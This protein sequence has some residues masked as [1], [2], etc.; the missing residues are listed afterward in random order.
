VSVYFSTRH[1]TTYISFHIM[2]NYLIYVWT[3]LAVRQIAA[4]R[5]M[6]C[7]WWKPRL[8]VSGD[9]R[10]QCTECACARRWGAGVREDWHGSVRAADGGLRGPRMCLNGNTAD[11]SIRGS[12]WCDWTSVVKS[13]VVFCSMNSNDFRFHF[14]TVCSCIWV[15][16]DKK[17]WAE[18]KT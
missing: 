16:Y 10:N 9:R 2:Y 13:S 7:L 14:H 17:T 18:F 6:E 12:N 4:I 8:Y 3:V 15:Q 5:V 11:K 1:L